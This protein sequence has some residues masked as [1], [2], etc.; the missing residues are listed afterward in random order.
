MNKDQALT[1]LKQHVKSENMIKHSTAA[2]AVL[3]ALAGRLGADIE[4][5]QA[6]G[7]LHDI[8]V[9]LT[10][11]DAKAHG[12]KARGLINGALPEEAILAIEAHNEACGLRPRSTR[13]DHALAAGETITGLITA[14]ALVYPDK[15]AA[16]VKA[17]SIT[18]RM[19]DKAFAASVNR[20][21]I[22]E[23]EKLGIPLPDFA[24][25]ALKAMQDIAGEL[26][27]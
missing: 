22:M 27:L 15:K 16:S 13:L 14:T 26:G 11:A 18:K 20:D 19:K 7:L 3:A 8:D 21:C 9:E 1:L 10:N 4:L 17:K 12:A 24:E 6:A 25:L 2:G 5:W 23:C